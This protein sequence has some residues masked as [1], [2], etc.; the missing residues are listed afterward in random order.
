[1]FRFTETA[2][3]CWTT[4]IH[5]AFRRALSQRCPCML[6]TTATGEKGPLFSL[7]ASQRRSFIFGWKSWKR[8]TPYAPLEKTDDGEGVVVGNVKVGIRSNALTAYERSEFIGHLYP[9]IRPRADAGDILALIDL[10]A[11]HAAYIHVT[12]LSYGSRAVMRNSRISM[13]TVSF[14]AFLFTR[15]VFLG[16]LIKVNTRVIHAGSSS[17][18]IYVRVHRQAYD[19]PVPQPVGESYVTMVIIDAKRLHVAPG[20]VPAVRLADPTD[21]E[22]HR[23]YLEWREEARASAK[24]TSGGALTREEVEHPDNK[25]KK[26]YLKPAEC[27]CRMDRSFGVGDVNINKAI[28][29]GEMLRFME[30]CALHCGRVFA[31]HARLYTLG[32]MDMTFDGPLFLHDLARCKAQVTYV[33]HSSLLVSVRVIALDSNGEARSTNRAS[34]ILVAI[35]SAGEPFEIETGI[36]LEGATQQELHTYWQGRRLMQ[37]SQLRRNKRASRA[38]AEK[39]AQYTETPKETEKNH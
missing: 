19:A 22:H 10:A 23:E 18:G 17:I 11:A 32:M 25:T 14:N 20:Y 13:A 38:A 4:P 1:M 21:N 9:L 7:Q 12:G 5:A 39:E 2:K 34:F 6:S 27:I 3:A 30:K 36:D 29:G 16:D 35:D 37:A 26:H 24:Q 8:R 31:R 28:F 33:Q 15:P